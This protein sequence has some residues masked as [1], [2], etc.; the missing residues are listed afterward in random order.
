MLVDR[1]SD[2]LFGST[3][4]PLPTGITHPV[5]RT[6]LDVAWDATHVLSQKSWLSALLLDASCVVVTS[7]ASV[8]AL[9]RMETTLGLLPDPSR[10]VA[11]I[12]GPPAKRWPRA[13]TGSLGPVTR[14]LLCARQVVAVPVE[15]GLK[16]T[17]VTP[18]PLPQPLLTAAGEILRIT[19][20]MPTHSKK[21]ES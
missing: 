3:D 4:V 6:V 10:V 2:I 7:V 18:E 11:A 14:R 5:T 12:V 15:T 8:P 19:E 21:D 1:C 9:R 16:I 13:L 17:G 20:A